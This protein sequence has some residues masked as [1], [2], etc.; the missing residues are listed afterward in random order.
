MRVLVNDVNV[1]VLLTKL[2]FDS[3]HNS[4]CK[5]LLFEE[6][7]FQKSVRFSLGGRSS[8]WSFLCTHR[9]WRAKPLYC[10]YVEPA[11]SFRMFVL[12]FLP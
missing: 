12:R 6:R 8:S 1:S 7:G 10:L 2:I 5:N 4:G 11:V 9:F 3:S